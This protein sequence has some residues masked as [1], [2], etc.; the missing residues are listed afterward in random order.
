MTIVSRG[1]R[2]APLAE[3]RSR[4]GRPG[5]KSRVVRSFI[6]KAAAGGVSY[7]RSVCQFRQWAPC[8]QVSPSLHSQAPRAHPRPL[9]WCRRRR[10]TIVLSSARSWLNSSRLGGGVL[11]IRARALPAVCAPRGSSRWLWSGGGI[12]GSSFAF[13]FSFIG[14]PKVPKQCACKSSL[15]RP[16]WPTVRRFC[17]AGEETQPPTTTLPC[18]FVVCWLGGE[19]GD[20]GQRA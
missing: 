4:C 13:A 12:G 6:R 11:P 16:Q 17:P 15:V 10:F 9:P 14:S 19:R 18:S 5:P 3:G 20:A 2:R 7:P 1:P 8:A